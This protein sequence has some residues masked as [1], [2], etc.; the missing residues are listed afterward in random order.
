MGES[1]VGSCRSF[2]IPIVNNCSCPI[3]FHLS[4][5]LEENPPDSEDNSGNLWPPL[6]EFFFAC[7]KLFL[8]CYLG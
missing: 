1:L 2:N 3:S 5:Q 4:V 6:L 7:L 8:F